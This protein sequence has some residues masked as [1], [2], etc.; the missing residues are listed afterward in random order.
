MIAKDVNLIIVALDGL[1]A[2]RLIFIPNLNK[3]GKT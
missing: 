1:R 3:I 2:D